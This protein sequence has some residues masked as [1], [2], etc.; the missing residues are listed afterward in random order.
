MSALVQIFLEAKE[1]VFNQ[2]GLAQISDGI[3][4]GVV[5]LE[6][7]QW[8]ELFAIQLVYAFLHVMRQHEVDKSLLLAAELAMQASAVMPPASLLAR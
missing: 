1:Q 4:D 3:G 5:V 8:R 7:E 2:L 6:L